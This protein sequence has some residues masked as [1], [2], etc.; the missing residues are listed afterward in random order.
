MLIRYLFFK[1]RLLFEE[2]LFFF[3]RVKI[4]KILGLFFLQEKGQT[5]MSYHTNNCETCYS[6]K[7]W[8]T[9]QEL[10]I[11]SICRKY[12][13]ILPTVFLILKICFAY[14]EMVWNVVCCKNIL[15][16]T[17]MWKYFYFYVLLHIIVC[18]FFHH[19]EEHSVTNAIIQSHVT[20][21][22]LMCRQRIG[23]V[24]ISMVLGNGSSRTAF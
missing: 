24:D 8:I 23:A 14:K 16:P 3:L 19:S 5:E 1:D 13:G 20:V 18:V 17:Y 21:S 22:S 6:D 15:S 7:I 2:H 10:N 11:S 9:T 4:H 12:F